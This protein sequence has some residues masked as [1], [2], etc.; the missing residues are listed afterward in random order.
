[1]TASI[2]YPHE[3]TALDPAVR[4][5]IVNHAAADG[6]PLSGLLYLPPCRDP[7]TVLLAQSGEKVLNAQSGELFG[8]VA[9]PDV[10]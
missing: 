2:R 7:D 9:G 5:E 6:V 4:R 10:P 8:R 3:F 1:M